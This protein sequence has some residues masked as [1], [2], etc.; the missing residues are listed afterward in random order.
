MEIVYD[1]LIAGLFS[2]VVM[3]LFE[4]PFWKYWGITGILEWHE[5]QV[6]ASKSIE[7]IRKI[8]YNQ[9]N[10][11]GIFL[12]HVI[13]GSLAAIGFPFVF[14]F[15]KSIFKHDILFSIILGIIYGILLWL[16]TLYPIHKPIT[17]LSIINHPLGKGPMIISICGHLL[18]GTTL[19]AFVYI[20][21]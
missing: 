10:Y 13:N 15:F 18:Y 19:G 20:L 7:K 14:L 2:T 16:L 8:E 1:G 5:N 3:T 6:L 17:G 4:I 12:L 9:I 11:F 21:I